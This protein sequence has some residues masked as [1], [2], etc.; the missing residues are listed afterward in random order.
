MNV[1]GALA[2]LLTRWTPLE[3]SVAA[4]LARLL[5]VILTAILLYVAYRVVTSLVTR[6]FSS[7]TARELHQKARNGLLC[8]LK[9]ADAAR[10]KSI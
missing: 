4:L 7:R 10:I 6:D 1:S 9:K 2:D 8:A 5:S 3:A